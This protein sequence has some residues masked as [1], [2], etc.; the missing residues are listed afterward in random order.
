MWGN[1]RWKN[2]DISQDERITKIYL[3]ISKSVSNEK[4]LGGLGNLVRQIICSFFSSVINGGK[5]Y[6]SEKYLI[7]KLNIEKIR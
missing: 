5:R 1:G 2:G 7:Y 4:A 3:I 6:K